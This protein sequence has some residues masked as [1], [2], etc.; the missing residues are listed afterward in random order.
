MTSSSDVC[1]FKAC[2]FDVFPFFCRL[3][4]CT[5]GLRCYIVRIY[6]GPQRSHMTTPLGP[7]YGSYPCKGP[8]GLSSVVRGLLGGSFPER[9]MHWCF[10]G[11]PGNSS[12]APPYMSQVPTIMEFYH[13]PIICQFY[14][15]DTTT[16]PGG[17][18]QSPKP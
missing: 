4:P 13:T 14:P 9:Q 1:G 16:Y 17:F 18:C 5:N 8:L 2:A 6:S 3:V 12:I 7:K 15:Y 10:T 11:V